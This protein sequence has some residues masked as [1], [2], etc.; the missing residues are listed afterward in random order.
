MSLACVSRLRSDVIKVKILSG[1]HGTSAWSCLRATITHE[2]VVGLYRGFLPAVTR[3]MPVI[4]VQMPLI[5]Q[6]RK[7]AGLGH[8]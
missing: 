2:G 4:L 5:E 8:L 6:V 7:M 1:D 3:Q